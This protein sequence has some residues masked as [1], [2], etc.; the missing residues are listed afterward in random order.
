[1]LEIARM[2]GVDP[3]ELGVSVTSRTYSNQFD[4]RKAF[5]DF[6]LGP[7]MTA[8]EQTLSGPNVVP[9]GYHARFDLDSFLRS[10]PAARYAAYAAGKA[11]GAL[12]DEDILK[13]ED[14]PMD[15]LPPDPTV[16]PATV[17]ENAS[18]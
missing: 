16:A 7:Y 8:I 18:V 17:E 11:V 13:A 4:R 15:T 5:L 14:K 1:V 6:T 9:Q 2:A 3:E 12:T 10:D